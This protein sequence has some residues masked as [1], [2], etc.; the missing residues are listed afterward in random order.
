MC[1]VSYGMYT[2]QWLDGEPSPEPNFQVHRQCRDY[3]ALLE[4]AKEHRVNRDRRVQ[5]VP[6]P[7]DLLIF[8]RM[9]WRRRRL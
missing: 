1:H 4:F 8:L 5:H 6:R 3:S 2:Y 7:V 9:L